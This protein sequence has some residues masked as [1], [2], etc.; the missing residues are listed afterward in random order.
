MPV[1]S[2][3]KGSDLRAFRKEAGISMEDL[4]SEA[5]LPYSRVSRVECGRLP[6]PADWPEKYTRAVQEL[7]RKRAIA[8]GV[9]KQ[10]GEAR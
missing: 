1:A 3:G 6:M 10:R 5:G 9:M 7:A 4:A 2:V 8:A